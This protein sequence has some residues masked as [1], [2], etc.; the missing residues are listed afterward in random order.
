MGNSQS[1]IMVSL[2][3]NPSLRE[4]LEVQRGH[5]DVISVCLMCQTDV[6]TTGYNYPIAQVKNFYRALLRSFYN[7]DESTIFTWTTWDVENADI[8]SPEHMDGVRNIFDVTISVWCQPQF[9]T[10]ISLEDY[11]TMCSLLKPGGF[12]MFHGGQ[13]RLEDIRDKRTPLDVTG[14]KHKEWERRYLQIMRERGHE[15]PE[16]EIERCRKANLEDNKQR[17]QLDCK[18]GVNMVSLFSIPPSDPPS[19]GVNQEIGV[20]QKVLV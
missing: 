17:V 1:P 20:M 19:H 12:L 7:T 13:R 9:A 4:D 11:Q 3:E 18:P 8:V 6:G 16:G 15:D 10:K 14:E 2:G 5:K